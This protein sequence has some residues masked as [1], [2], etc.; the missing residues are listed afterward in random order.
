MATNGINELIAQDFMVKRSLMRNK[1]FQSD[2]F[3]SRWF[4]LTYTEIKYL[5][6]TLEVC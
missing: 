4:Q 1:L 2:N 6:G 5:D 3:R